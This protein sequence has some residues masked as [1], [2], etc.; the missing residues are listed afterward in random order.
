[1]PSCCTNEPLNYDGITAGNWLLR[2]IFDNTINSILPVEFDRQIAAKI[3]G[4][5]ETVRSRTNNGG[6]TKALVKV[7][8][9]NSSFAIKIE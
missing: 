3:K 1:M 9:I 2:S 5:V 7:V 6:S 4:F 8:I